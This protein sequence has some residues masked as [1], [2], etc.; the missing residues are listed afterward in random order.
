[1]GYHLLT[2]AS[3]SFGYLSRHQSQPD[4]SDHNLHMLAWGTDGGLGVEWRASAPQKKPYKNSTAIASSPEPA[5]GVSSGHWLLSALAAIPQDL[6]WPP[7]TFTLAIHKSHK[8]QDPPG[9]AS[10]PQPTLC[11]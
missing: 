1:M 7:L 5:W 3:W 9:S 8:P 4:L 11:S 6:A 10:T 2:S